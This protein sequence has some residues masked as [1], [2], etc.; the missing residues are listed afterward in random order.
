[1]NKEYNE[2]SHINFRKKLDEDIKWINETYYKKMKN[3]FSFNHWEGLNKKR[4][5]LL[6]GL[7]RRMEELQKMNEILLKKLK[8]G[9]TKVD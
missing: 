4:I 8:Y 1:M 3:A 7:N 6:M 2:N 9:Q 5:Q